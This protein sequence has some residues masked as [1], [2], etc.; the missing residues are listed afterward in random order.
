MHGTMKKKKN[1]DTLFPMLEERHRCYKPNANKQTEF[2]Q[3]VK[4]DISIKTTRDLKF[5]R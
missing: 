4:S 1:G 2:T 5:S 3:P